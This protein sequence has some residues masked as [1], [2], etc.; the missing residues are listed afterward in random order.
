ML[1]DQILMIVGTAVLSSALTV[2]FLML[3]F[4]RFA[5]Q[6]ETRLERRLQERLEASAQEIGDAMEARLRSVIGDAVRELKHASLAAG[7]TR[8]VANSG[9]ELLQEGLRILM[10]GGVKPSGGE[11]PSGGGTR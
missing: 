6:V 9:A 3:F 11:G 5:A 10:G 7:A 8:T 1:L 4:R 2:G